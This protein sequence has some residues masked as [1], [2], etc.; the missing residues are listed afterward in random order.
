M[1]TCENILIF[2]NECIKNSIHEILLRNK[3]YEYF[4]YIDPN[5]VNMKTGECINL[6]IDKI[7]LTDYYVTM[8]Y[9]K[10]DPFL[11]QIKYTRMQTYH[12]KELEMSQIK[13]FNSNVRVGV[14]LNHERSRLFNVHNGMY[15]A[16][17][18]NN[19][20]CFVCLYG[21]DKKDFLFEIDFNSCTKN[22]QWFKKLEHEMIE[23]MKKH[24]FF[25]TSLLN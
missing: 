12:Y 17:Q 22:G 25:I 2:K 20:Y 18:L 24:L 23:V 3:A 21:R 13:M 8:N 16:I 5:V 19:I 7:G 15:R 10:R 9:F 1:K 11:K 6:G 14:F 4:H